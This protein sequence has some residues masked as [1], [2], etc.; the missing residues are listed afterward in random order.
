M[1]L[2]RKELMTPKDISQEALAFLRG[3]IKPPKDDGRNYALE[4]IGRFGCTLDSF[5]SGGFD[6]SYSNK[7]G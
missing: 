1:K 4:E 5:P 2:S 6:M 7:F 3:D